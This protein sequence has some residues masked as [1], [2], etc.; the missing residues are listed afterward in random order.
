MAA[1]LGVAVGVGIANLGGGSP[2]GKVTFAQRGGDV[3]APQVTVRGRASGCEVTRVQADEREVS[4][5]TVGGDQ[6]TSVRPNTVAEPTVL[7]TVTILHNNKAVYQMNWVA[8]A[9]AP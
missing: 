5:K 8:V 1:L 9:P 7:V 3:W 4:V 2:S 6:L